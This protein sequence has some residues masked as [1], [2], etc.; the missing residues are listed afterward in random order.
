MRR[1]LF[2]LLMILLGCA[3]PMA[4]DRP[5]LWWDAPPRTYS[6]TPQ[7]ITLTLYYRNQGDAQIQM[8]ATVVEAGITVERLPG[9][10]THDDGVFRTSFR[11]SLPLDARQMVPAGLYHFQGMASGGRFKASL[12]LQV[13]N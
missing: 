6:T 13:E 3:G 8:D 2:P 12:A 1:L 11:V 7:P 5:I 9:P 4:P 10:V